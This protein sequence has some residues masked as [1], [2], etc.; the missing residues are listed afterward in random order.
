[1]R[2]DFAPYL[3]EIRK[4]HC[5]PCVET[6][7]ANRPASDS[8]AAAVALLAV[9]RAGAHQRVEWADYI[10]AAKVQ[11]AQRIAAACVDGATER[12]M[13]VMERGYSTSRDS[14]FWPYGPAGPMKAHE[15]VVGLGIGV[16]TGVY[17]ARERAYNER[18]AAAERQRALHVERLIEAD[19]RNRCTY[20]RVT[21]RLCDGHGE[22]APVPLPQQRKELAAVA[23]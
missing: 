13:V 4:C 11:A 19:G 9:L 8:L 18:V 1:M 3:D 10:V 22:Y 23:V 15:F 17:E 6:S 2:A 14:D 20:F 16:T 12:R 21:G 7:Y 5:R